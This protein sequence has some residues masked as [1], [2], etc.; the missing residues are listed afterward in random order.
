M[1]CTGIYGARLIKANEPTKKWMNK[2][3][4]TREK[5]NGATT[6]W[7]MWCIYGGLK[8]KFEK[9][10]WKKIHEFYTGSI[11][12]CSFQPDH[13]FLIMNSLGHQFIGKIIFNDENATRLH[14]ISNRKNHWKRILP[15][16]K[17]NYL[18]FNAHEQYIH[19]AFFFLPRMETG[20]WKKKVNH[21]LV[22]KS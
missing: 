13:I 15:V 10:Y 3:T 1:K 6:V 2:L 17:V 8:W 22:L 16:S 18:R 14:K 19:E 11:G 4:T 5:K 12:S 7:E 21:K 20:E 9:I